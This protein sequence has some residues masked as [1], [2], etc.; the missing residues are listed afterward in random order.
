MH[1][2]QS[3]YQVKALEQSK[4]HHFDRKSINQ[5]KKKT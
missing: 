2:V 1:F 4:K 5:K 3:H